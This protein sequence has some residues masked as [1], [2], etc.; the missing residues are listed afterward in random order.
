MNILLAIES[1]WLAVGFG[2]LCVLGVVVVEAFVLYLFRLNSF[3]RC[4]R[5]SIMAN[6]GSGLLCLLLLLVLNKVEIDGLTHLIIFAFFFLVSSFFET[7]LIRLLNN[8]LSWS[9]ILP[10]SLVMNLL[11]YAAGYWV[12]ST[13][14]F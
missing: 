11:T 1:I 3:G 9:K 8:Q 5:D 4:F 10:A 6:I 7:W 2:F 13:Y 14:M 12:F